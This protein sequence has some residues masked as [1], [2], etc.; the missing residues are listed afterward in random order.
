MSKTNATNATPAVSVIIPV[1]NSKE[2]L[3][4][5]MESVLGQDLNDIEI[6]I[7]DDGSN[8]GSQDLCDD[9]ASKHPNITVIHRQH[10]GLGTALNAGIDACKGEY[11]GF[12]DANDWIDPGMYSVLYDIA[13]KNHTDVVSSLV[14]IYE[15][16][17]AGEVKSGFDRTHYNHNIYNRFSAVEFYLK[18]NFYGSSIYKSELIKKHHIAFGDQED[19]LAY[20]LTFRFLVFSFMK[21]LFI[22]RAAFYHHNCN[23]KSFGQNAYKN[24]LDILHGHALINGLIEERNIENRMVA[25]EAARALSEIR[26]Q[27]KIGCSSLEQRVEY[28]NKSSPLLKKYL[29]LSKNNYFLTKHDRK[30]LRSIANH[31]LL[32]AFLDENNT[33][34]KIQRALLNMQFKDKVSFIKIFGFPL[35]F[36]KRTED[37]KTFNICK[38]PI[39]KVKKSSNHDRS[40]VKTKYYY[41]FLPLAK[42]MDT[43]KE[44]KT[45]WI[46]IMVSK[47]PNLQYY[48]DKMPTSGEIFYYASMANTVALV[49]GKTFPQFK[50]SNVGKTVAIYGTGPSL[51]YAPKV[52]NVKTIACNRAIK[53]FKDKGPDYF[54]AVD[55]EGAHDYFDL[56]LKS[57]ASLFWGAY[58]HKGLYSNLSIP[59]QLRNRDNV[60]SFY[61]SIG[62]PDYVIR[63]EI[64]THPLA[65]FNTI[66]HCALHFA[67]YTN[68]DTI[69]VLGCDTTNSGYA[70]KNMY[71]NKI[72]VGKLVEGYTKMEAFRKRHYPNTRIIS[73]N[74]IGLRGIFEDVYTKGF[75]DHS[76]EL[77]R[78][79]ITYTDSI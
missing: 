8:D 14:Y 35:L 16:T 67:L 46:N 29:Y 25:L 44:I 43:G 10:S 55:Y 73:V 74:P 78:S 62:V 3:A 75:A 54:F 37:Y 15:D 19:F 32:T 7:T 18:P 53:L 50:D 48:L 33:H 31:P 68:P 28:L 4:R 69:Y 59:E 56:V 11:I 12:V 2:N 79:K 61:T 57:R 26:E 65:D 36:I 27:F 22:F 1:Y 47:K 70:E 20:D 66:V 21:S 63:P 17:Q 23:V 42:V 64:E 52:T 9:Y 38:I 39:R 34:M 30:Y 49:H 40:I 45:Y 24:A 51:D 71:Q 5:C 13:S 41:F 76:P 72:D 60:F 77:D 6:I 58:I